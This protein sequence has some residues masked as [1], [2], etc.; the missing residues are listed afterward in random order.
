MAKNGKRYGVCE[1]FEG[2]NKAKAGAK[3]EL[4]ELDDFICPECHSDLHEVHTSK[5]PNMKLIGAIAT[6]IVLGGGAAA[7]FTLA[8]LL[9]PTVTELRFNTSSQELFIGGSDT[10]E[11]NNTPIDSEATYI[12][13]S[14]NESVATVNNGV[15]TPVSAGKV[16][17]TVKAQENELASATCEYIIK[18][19]AKVKPVIV[20]E[21]REGP[22]TG[23]INLGYAV[24]EGPQQNG[25]PHGIGGKLTFKTSHTIDL[26]KMP[27][28]Y[29]DVR[30]GDSMVSV[31]FDNG[32]LVQGEIRFADGTRKWIHI[33]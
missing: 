28:E 18:D 29:I 27:A 20:D 6:V 9:E 7:Y 19:T 16:T 33:G 13:S 25:K 1:N 32:R 5:G 15:V 10:L 21:P 12:W 8:P 11:V 14:D 2:C 24:Y 23:T 4:D 22:A 26:K 3:I 31:K 17:I 30:S